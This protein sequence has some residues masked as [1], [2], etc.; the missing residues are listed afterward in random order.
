[1]ITDK[2]T[3]KYYLKKDKQA[4][5]IKRKYPR[6]FG[7]EIWKY[8]ILLRKEEYYLNTQKKILHAIYKIK[9]HKLGLKLGFTIPCNVFEEGLRINHYGYL[10]VSGKAKIGK[11]CDI[12]QGVNIGVDLN[13]NA[14]TIGDN[15]Y[16]GP[17]AKLFGDINIGNDTM[18]GAGAVVTKSFEKGNVR[19]AGVPAK[20][21]SEEGNIYHRE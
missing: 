4:L 19:I 16:I 18:I 13:Q 12:H 8:E 1:M 9:R 10:V 6:I 17:G 7:D 2:D 3:L 5:N 20:V 21:I 14:P 11:F 15:V